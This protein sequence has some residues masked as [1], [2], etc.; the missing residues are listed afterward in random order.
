[1]R[2]RIFTPLS[3]VIDEEVESLRAV[4]ASGGFGVLPGHVPF[5]T[6]LAIC[7][8]SW[9]HADEE[10]YCALRGGVLTVARGTKIAIATREAVVGDDLARLD[11]EV[12]ERFA[13]DAEA[14]RVEHVEAMRA[15]MNAIR[16]MI[17]RLH[18]SGN[19]ESFR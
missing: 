14:E 19:R 17:N 1:M 9:R 6:A 18:P 7:I 15:Q 10:K 16:R 8:V 3:T 4:D 12:L 13:A 11:T 2:L 5:T